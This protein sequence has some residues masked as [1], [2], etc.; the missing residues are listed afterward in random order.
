MSATLVRPARAARVLF[1][2]DFDGLEGVTV[3]EAPPE[4]EVIVPAFTAADRE[5]IRERA[6]AE[7][8]AAAAVEAQAAH[9]LAVQ[10]ALAGIETAL[11][12]L[13]EEQ[14]DAALRHA[15]DV[16]RLLLDTLF[17]LL[18]ALCARHGET[19]VR[20]VAR[21][22]LPALAREPAVT[23]RVH[24]ELAAAVQH[25]IAQLD[26]EFARRV[27]LIAVET[28]ARGDVRVGWADGHAVRDTGLAW[29][30][31]AAALSQAGLLLPPA[32]TP[33]DARVG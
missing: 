16:A 21:A 1:A 7:G 15:E 10:D 32:S 29:R 12:T 19:E 27:S 11:R 3:I 13:D 31:V 24:P 33:E 18:P 23:V 28:V 25:E 8:R 6:Y 17:T 2:E 20:A 30:Q 5:I 22:V 4:P 9:R 14:A 26:P